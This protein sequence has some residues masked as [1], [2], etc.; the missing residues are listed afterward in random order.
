MNNKG[1]AITG[2]LYSLLLVF[3]TILVMLLF[4]FQNKKNILDKLKDDTFNE[5]NGNGI[6]ANQ[7]IFEPDDVSWE[8]NTVHDALEYLR[9]IE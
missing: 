6:S 4:N 9:Y 2:I 7:L 5:L 8:V 1:F 3:V